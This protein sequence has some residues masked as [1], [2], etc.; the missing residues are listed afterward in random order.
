MGNI[1]V[2]FYFYSQSS[3]WSFS[4]NSFWSTSPISISLSSAPPSAISLFPLFRSFSLRPSRYLYLIT[5]YQLPVYKQKTCYRGMPQL[6]WAKQYKFATMLE[7]FVSELVQ[8]IGLCVVVVHLHFLRLMPLK[9]LNRD[10]STFFYCISFD[11]IGSANVVGTNASFAWHVWNKAWNSW[12]TFCVLFT[13]VYWEVFGIIQ[14]CNC[15]S[16][17]QCHS[18]LLI[19]ITLHVFFLKIFRHL[20]LN[21]KVWISH[22]PSIF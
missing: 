16:L 3:K 21:L 15:W 2:I 17:W 11:R 1:G 4:S 8:L 10:V 5:G 13:H 14:W 19:T 20:I 6:T 18:M 7:N 9:E 12:N 22:A